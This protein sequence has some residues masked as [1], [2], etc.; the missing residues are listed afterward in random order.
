MTRFVALQLARSHSY[1][2]AP[3]QRDFG[4]REPLSL[5][6][7]TERLVESLRATP[8]LGVPDATS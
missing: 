2:M 7:A 1:D 5:E 6:Q 3:A 8:G 4:F